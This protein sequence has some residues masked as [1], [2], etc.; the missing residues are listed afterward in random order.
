MMEASCRYD[1]YDWKLYKRRYP[2][3]TSEL[4]EVVL[5]FSIFYTWTCSNFYLQRFLSPRTMLKLLLLFASICTVA[6]PDASAWQVA[7][8]L[9]AAHVCNENQVEEDE[10]SAVL[11]NKIPVPSLGGAGRT[12][13]FGR[14][15]WCAALMG[16]GPVLD[17]FSGLG[18][19]TALLAN[20]LTHRPSNVERRLVTFERRPERLEFVADRLRGQ[21]ATVHMLD[22]RSIGKEWGFNQG[23]S[24]SDGVILIA[25]STTELLAMVS[26]D[27]A[28][29]LLV[30]DPDVETPSEDFA[31]DWR[32]L[33]K[34][35]PN[36]VAFL[37]HL[38]PQ[39]SFC[40][41]LKTRM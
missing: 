41:L 32:I 11:C 37:V 22:A 10:T 36:V 30:L 34:M 38:V 19:S 28:P 6:A 8:Q 21:N 14:T 33:E 26:K 12:T 31:A 13:L 5:W 9:C 40:L 39:A 1:D 29:G 25:G 23:G 7:L 3:F 15:I 27:L 16:Q 17:L 4:H 2:V 20:A 24:Q 18:D 35:N